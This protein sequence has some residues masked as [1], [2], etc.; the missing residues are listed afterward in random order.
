MTNEQIGI[1]ARKA[2]QE[3]N[4]DLAIVLHV[5]LGSKHVGMTSEFA[6]HCQAFARE[7]AREINMRLNKRNN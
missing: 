1:L 2:T 6:R 5:Y 4:N 7:G 3:G